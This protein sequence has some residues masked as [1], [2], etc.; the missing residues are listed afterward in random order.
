MAARG[1]DRGLV[2]RLPRACHRGFLPKQPQT[3]AQGRR[4]LRPWSR[5]GLD[6]LPQDSDCDRGDDGGIKRGSPG[7]GGRIPWRARAGSVDLSRVTG[8][9][10]MC[11]ERQIRFRPVKAWL[12]GRTSL[13]MLCWKQNRLRC[14]ALEF[15][16]GSLDTNG[17][18]CP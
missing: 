18:T 15:V 11:T 1:E 5:A 7:G 17:E 14:P 9:T 12:D 8:S 6:C 4:V 3:T 10:A 13:E 2:D 16:A